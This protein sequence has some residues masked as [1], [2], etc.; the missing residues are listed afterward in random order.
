[1]EKGT[2]ITLAAGAIAVIGLLIGVIAYTGMTN[3]EKKVE[4]HDQQIDEIRK[5]VSQEEATRQAQDTDIRKTINTTESILNKKIS[6]TESKLEAE[7]QKIRGDLD[8]LTDRLS[9]Y[10]ETTNAQI[11]A[12]Q[13]DIT[14]NK[15]SIEKAIEDAQTAIEQA[16]KELSQNITRVKTE[17]QAKIIQ[18][19]ADIAGLHI[20]LNTLKARTSGINQSITLLNKWTH[21]RTDELQTHIDQTNSRINQETQARQT[22]TGQIEQRIIVLDSKVD[23]NKQYNDQKIAE[24]REEI[25]NQT[26]RIAAIEQN[27]TAVWLE[28]AKKAGYWKSLQ[29]LKNWLTEDTTDQN[30]YIP[31]IYDCDDFATDLAKH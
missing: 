15:A 28:L 3:N 21:D 26:A 23:A 10:E 25:D 19:Q 7:I 2:T 24:A 11:K 31:V 30:E 22:E 1:M 14:K 8:N 20:E 17:L 12:L 16:R 27:L 9:R 5:T 6:D 29:E 18:M 13:E 4:M